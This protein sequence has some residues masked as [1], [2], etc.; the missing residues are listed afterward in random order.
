MVGIPCKKLITVGA[1]TECSKNLK[2]AS[3]R[4]V[5]LGQQ[6]IKEYLETHGRSTVKELSNS[7]NLHP[8]S[9]RSSLRSMQK[10]N[11][12]EK[13]NGEISYKADQWDLVKEDP[14]SVNDAETS[15]EEKLREVKPC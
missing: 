8:Q 12:V 9:I 7:L 3:L 15:T 13:H 10:W 2:A 5:L 11:E 4:V 6:E 14:E 1:I